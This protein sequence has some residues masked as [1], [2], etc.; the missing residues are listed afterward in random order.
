MVANAA[1]CTRCRGCAILIGMLSR[2]LRS[3]RQNSFAG[4]S[5][6]FFFRLRAEPETEG[7]IIDR[8]LYAHVVTRCISAP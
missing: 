8:G 7:V 4:N 2:F 6:R 5:R 3:S 1:R